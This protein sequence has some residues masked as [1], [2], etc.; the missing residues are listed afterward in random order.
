MHI[1]ITIAGSQWLKVLAVGAGVLLMFSSRRS[2]AGLKDGSLTWQ[3]LA[4]GPRGTDQRERAERRKTPDKKPTI[5]SNTS[6]WKH[7]SMKHPQ[8]GGQREFHGKETKQT[9]PRRLGLYHKARESPASIPTT[10]SKLAWLQSGLEPKLDLPE[11]N[12][13]RTHYLLLLFQ[14]DTL[15]T[16]KPSFLHTITRAESTDR[17]SR[18]RKTQSCLLFP[19]G[20]SQPRWCWELYMLGNLSGLSPPAGMLGEIQLGER[21]LPCQQEINLVVSELESES[22]FS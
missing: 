7:M 8:S 5:H 4:P 22:I 20:R 6:S 9:L 1:S 17:P 10:Q 21:H 3:P 18:K 11:W 12:Q 14:Q 16:S 15:H 13:P 19:K 2:T